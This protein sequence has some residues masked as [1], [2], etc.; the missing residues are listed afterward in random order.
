[1]TKLGRWP[2][3]SGRQHAGW[4][5]GSCRIIDGD[6]PRLEVN[7]RQFACCFFPVAA[8]DRNGLAERL[9]A[10]GGHEQ[11]VAREDIARRPGRQ[12]SGRQAGIAGDRQAPACGAVDPGDGFDYLDDG[13]NIGLCA[14]E[15]AWH[16]QPR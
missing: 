7:G 1:M 16:P 8:L 4:I 13:G 5:Q 12:I 15:R 10:P 2:F 3:A 11:R 14:T 9:P 6:K